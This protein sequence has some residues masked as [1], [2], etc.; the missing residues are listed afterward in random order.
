MTNGNRFYQKNIRWKGYDYSLQNAYCITIC[1]YQK[2]LWFGKII[3]NEMVLNQFGM[4]AEQE[5]LKIPNHRPYVILYEYVVM[6]NHF[7][8]IFEIKRE[9]SDN[10]CF[11]PKEV[12]GN[13]MKDISPRPESVSTIIGSYKSAVTREIN[14]ISTGFAWQTRFYDRVIRNHEEYT[15]LGE[16]I[17]ANPENWEKDEHYM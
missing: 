7:H 4:I 5:W 14:K 8:G 15:R 3:N 16:Y 9:T 10:I 11:K 6:P 1:T 2:Q 13:H 12:T 17:M